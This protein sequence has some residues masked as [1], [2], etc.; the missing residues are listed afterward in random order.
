MMPR[1]DWFCSEPTNPVR[2]AWKKLPSSHQVTDAF[3]SAMNP[4]MTVTTNAPAATAACLNRL[5]SSR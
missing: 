4:M 1:S 3:G 2:P 5:V